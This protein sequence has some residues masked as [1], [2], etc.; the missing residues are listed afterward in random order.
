[1]SKKIQILLIVLCGIL[2]GV[3]IFSGY[4]LLTDKAEH[5]DAR[6]KDDEAKV[7]YQRKQTLQAT[8]RP[9]TDNPEIQLDDEISPLNSM[10]LDQFYADYPDAVGW[11]YSPNGLIDNGVVEAEDND[12]YLHRFFDGSYS[13]S[14]SIFVDC[15]CSRDFSDRNTIIYG[16]HMNDGTKF[17]SLI[18]YR[19]KAYYEKYPVLY[20]STKDMNYR[21]EIFS[22]YLTDAESDSYTLRFETDNEYLAYLSK[23]CARSDFPSD[24]KL[25]STDRIITLSTCSY[26]YNDARYVVHGK[27]VPIH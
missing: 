15:Q 8:P 10:D 26:E 9:Y 27:L 6:E 3:M 24:V 12:F 14:G 11:I 19:E 5:K 23:I 17:A 7:T 2:F 1:M 20:L 13:I 4:K 21:V 18:N 22:A 16:H 25:S